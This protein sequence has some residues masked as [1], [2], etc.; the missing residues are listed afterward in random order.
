M[1]DRRDF[2]KKGLLAAIATG[3]VA[4]FSSARQLVQPLVHY[5]TEAELPIVLSTWSHGLAANEA[6]W[7]KLKTVW[8]MAVCLMLTEML[9]WMPAS[10]GRMVMRAQ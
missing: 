2:I 10:W 3:W 5:A 6:A 8:A 4:K 9:R 7:G 1:S